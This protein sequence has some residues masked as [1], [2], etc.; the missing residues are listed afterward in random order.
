MNSE[1]GNFVSGRPRN[2]DNPKLVLIRSEIVYDILTL[3]ADG[4]TRTVEA[5]LKKIEADGTVSQVK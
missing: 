4:M 5:D 2:Q 3:R 1:T